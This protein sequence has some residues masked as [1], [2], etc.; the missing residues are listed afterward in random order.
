M[1]GVLFQHFEFIFVKKCPSD[2]TGHTAVGCSR[3]MADT[4]KRPSV[5]RLVRA[6]EPQSAYALHVLVNLPIQSHGEESI[7][8][9][10][11]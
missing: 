5:G 9:W 11:D 6:T 3:N 8:G 2:D 7:A 10:D 1:D 4:G